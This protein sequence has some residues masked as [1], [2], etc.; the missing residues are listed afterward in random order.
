MPAYKDKKN[1]KWYCKFYYK[2]WT[3]IR[4]GELFALT[5][6]DIDFQ[7]KEIHI[8]KTY[9]RIQGAD[10]ITRPKTRKSNRSILMPDFLCEELW[11]YLKSL[12]CDTMSERLFPFTRYFLSYEMKRGCERTGIKKIRI[13]DDRVIIGASQKKPSKIKGLQM[14]LSYYFLQ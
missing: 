4:S 8:E 14:I 3:G 10:V 9:Q 7:K 2:D 1:G 13:H 11:E 12:S 6:A 5:P